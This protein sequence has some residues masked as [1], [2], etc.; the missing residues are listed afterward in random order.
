MGQGHEGL[1]LIWEGAG[2]RERPCQKRTQQ[3]DKNRVVFLA[4]CD[5]CGWGS[6][7]QVLIFSNQICHILHL[8]IDFFPLVQ[9]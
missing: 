3:E 7:N 2:W 1:A 8:M 6:S 5:I 4:F 9:D